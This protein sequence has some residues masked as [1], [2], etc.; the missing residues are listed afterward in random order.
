MFKFLIT[1]VTEGNKELPTPWIDLFTW[2][3]LANRRELARLI[4][5]R[6]RENLALALMASKLLKGL[7]EKALSERDFQDIGVD[8]LDHAE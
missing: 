4:W 7:V 2:A 6:C 1:L 5:E 8:M 3:V